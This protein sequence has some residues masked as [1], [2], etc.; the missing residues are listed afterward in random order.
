MKVYANVTNAGIYSPDW[1]FWDPEFRNRNSDGAISTAIPP[2]YYS[3][4]LNVTF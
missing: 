2:R 1:T 3:L 4:G